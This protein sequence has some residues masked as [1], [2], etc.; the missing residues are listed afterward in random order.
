M[1]REV[2]YQHIGIRKSQASEG[3]S[4]VSEGKSGV[5]GGEKWDK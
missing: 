2:A 4:G 1:K 3:R 5:I